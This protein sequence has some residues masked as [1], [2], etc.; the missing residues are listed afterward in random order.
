M[1][2]L[3][4][5]NLTR[6]SG[7]TKLKQGDF[8][9]VL[10]YSLAD[11][12]GQEI[13]SFDTKTAYI[14]LVLD[15]KILF[16]TTTQVDISRV[17]FHIDKALPI[18][19]YYLEIKID[20]YV[21]PSDKDS[22]ILIEEGATAY[23]LKD[24]IP[25]YDVAMTI[26]GILS[27]LSKKGIDITDLNRRIGNAN[28]ELIAS[29]NGKS[30]L[31]TRID[32]LENETTA[33]LAQKVGMQGV[34]QVTM[35]NLSQPIKDALTGGSVAVVGTQSTGMPQLTTD[36]QNMLGSY[37]EIDLTFENG[38]WNSDNG[39][40]I[41][42]DPSGKRTT[43]IA[44]EGDRFKYT[45]YF[46]VIT[47]GVSFVDSNGVFLDKALPEV[48]EGTKKSDVEIICPA[49]TAMIKI[50]NYST[51]ETRLWKLQ[52][53]PDK[54]ATNIALV[55]ESDRISEVEKNISK[56]DFGSI[57][58]N[59][60]SL[61]GSFDDFKKRA[62]HV[63]FLNDGSQ[64]IITK[65]SLGIPYS[66]GMQSINFTPD[67][68]KLLHVF[69]KGS[70]D[71][72]TKPVN[73]F[74]WGV[75]AGFLGTGTSKALTPTF[76]EHLVFDPNYFSIYKDETEFYVMIISEGDG[77]ITLDRFEVIQSSV[78][79]TN[80]ISET[81]EGVVKNIDTQLSTQDS[82]ITALEGG[83][84]GGQTILTSPNGNKYVNL[85]QDT[86][87]I[88]G[89]KLYP[90]KTLFLGNS[91]M[92][93]WNMKFGMASTNSQSDYYYHVKEKIKEYRPSASFTKLYTSPWE[94]EAIERPTFITDNLD[95]VLTA[96]T[97]LVIIQAGENVAQAGVSK[98]QTDGI[99]LVRHIRSIATKARVLFVGVWYP[100]TPK[101]N[102]IQEI[103]RQTGA[104]FCN[105]SD[106]YSPETTGK[107]G[108]VITYDNDTTAT[109]T[110]ESQASH[111]GNV[112]MQ[113]I[114]DRIIASL[115]L[116][117]SL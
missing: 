48:T 64:F 91:L 43:Y 72:T 7:G 94:S 82:R 107:I 83:D 116:T 26:T 103:C 92:F 1:E 2:I 102:A 109:I 84:V 37:V 52:S 58:V 54:Y 11:E 50:S 44:S 88:V 101:V 53:H 42:N 89:A 97:D 114:A 73:F 39:S 85:V 21:F 34:G 4:T 76:D 38:Y 75:T 51:T 19:L 68:T 40:A 70:H 56:I 23:D 60:P 59:P 105:I 49:N 5:L 8:G 16:T 110:L 96:D 41:G 12:N 117:Q 24:L 100:D 86:G 78:L 36:L 18:G 112:G 81:L 111:P 108:D 27:D 35:Q 33:Q 104:I 17:T 45:G 71:I 87:D 6:I 32:D 22:V 67:P 106:I 79:G 13:T 28:A 25:N 98:F 77:Q 47:T 80:I 14:N 69:L 61:I 15:D 31:K 55:N 3:N 66:D 62:G 63:T 30:N 57:K 20:D 95:P 10:S 93:G 74:I 115:G 9:S 99:A 46:G 65:P 29:R 113:M 90:D